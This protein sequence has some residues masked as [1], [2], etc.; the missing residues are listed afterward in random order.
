MDN[1]TTARERG[2]PER[3]LREVANLLH[4]ELRTGGQGG[5]T[6]LSIAHRA[7]LAYK[8]MRDQ[9]DEARAALGMDRPWPFRDVVRKLADAAD[10]L[11]NHHSCDTHGWEEIATARDEA[12]AFLSRTE[13]LPA[14]PQAEGGGK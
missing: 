8:A 2:T 13:P 7:V 5:E 3:E 11:L 9:R 14:A 1:E 6:C 12:R 4:D 10:H